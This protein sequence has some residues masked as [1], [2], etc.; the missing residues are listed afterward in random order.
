MLHGMDK[1]KTQTH[2]FKGLNDFFP[3]FVGGEQVD[4]NGTKK[5]W[6]GK[7]LDQIVANTKKLIDKNIFSGAP[8]VIGHPKADAPA[9]GW[10]QDLKRE[11]SV[12][13]VKGDKLHDEFAEG[14][15]KGL[16][17]NRSI[18]IGKGVDGFYLKHVGFLGAVPPAIEGMDSIYNASTDDECFDY[19]YQD[20]ITP[21]ILSRM[22]RRMR[23]FIIDK[24]DIETADKIIPD[25]EIE[26]LSDHASSLREEDTK[27][28]PS[29]SKPEP[30]KTGDE[31]M[32]QF[33]QTQLDDAVEAAVKKAT[34]HL[35]ADFSQK[36]KTHETALTAERNKRLVVEF[37]EA[38]TALV[39]DGKL[40]PA[41]AEGMSEFMLQLSDAEEANFEFSAGEKGKEETFK[42]SP[43]KWFNDFTKALGKQIDFKESDAGDD[44]TV[45]SSSDFSVSG[46]DVNSE[47][48]ELHNK[49]SEYM[50]SHEGVDYIT[51]VKAVEKSQS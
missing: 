45:S 8:M 38:I 5:A 40:L 19:S 33:S 51:A 48:L 15:E 43:L 3:A 44:D 47:R 36:E 4:S 20:S 31:P 18:R 28:T 41:Q 12:L 32:T 10:I 13:S 39:D 25:Y 50:D 11:G 24:F 9:Y 21:N 23:D 27:S 7:E 29:Y 6:T 34:K 49:A 30:K 1:S 26:S 22:M 35:N 42:K 16:W 37:S 17:P 46:A 14:V 2:D